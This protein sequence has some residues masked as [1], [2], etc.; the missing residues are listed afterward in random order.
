MDFLHLGM[1]N[2][3]TGGLGSMNCHRCRELA[4]SAEPVESMYCTNLYYT[5]EFDVLV[6]TEGNAVESAGELGELGKEEF[7]S[8]GRKLGERVLETC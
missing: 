8:A 5:T 1:K 6:R 2:C 4:V 7:V 3:R